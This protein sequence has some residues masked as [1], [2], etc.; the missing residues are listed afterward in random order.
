MNVPKLKG[1]RPQSMTV[2]LE[3]ISPMVQHQW[4]EKAKK[5]MLDKKQGK[6]TKNREPCDPETEFIAAAYKTAGGK[7]AIPATAVKK[8][9]IT[10]AH[11]DLGI[12]KT[13][14]KKSLF[15]LADET[16]MIELDCGEPTMRQDVVRVGMGSTDL[17]YRPEFAEWCVTAE[18][19]YDA[20]NLRTDDIVTLLD[21]AGFGVGLGEMR[22]ERGGDYGRFRVKEHV[23]A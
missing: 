12:E 14:V 21:R 9:I 23:A 22:P 2:V 6:K 16:G 3:G 13:L 19:Q 7:Y 8:A 18:I 20:E 11:K 5:A 1:V 4:S 10:A 15:V 17:R